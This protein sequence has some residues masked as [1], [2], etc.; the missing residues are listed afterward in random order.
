M[1]DR[2][3]KCLQLLDS[4]VEGER[5]AAFNVSWP[6]M[7]A[8][9]LRFVDLYDTVMTWGGCAG[10]LETQNRE[11]EARNTGLSE[12]VRR[13]MAENARL[14]AENAI[15][16]TPAPQPAPKHAKPVK[17]PF[18]WLPLAVALAIVV[19]GAL[20]VGLIVG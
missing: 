8:A 1:N 11:L 4:P 10:H 3:H 13:L 2:L 19:A 7:V 17:E 5:I 16:R 18:D 14:M 6:M 9:G 15:L 20:C 12:E